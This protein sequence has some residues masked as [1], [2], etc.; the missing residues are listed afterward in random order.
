MAEGQF[1]G[2]KSRVIYTSDADDSIILTIDDDLVTSGQSLPT[3]N[4]ASPPENVT[5]KPNRF[6]PRGVYWQATQGD[7]AGARKF[8]ICGSPD[9]PLYSTNAQT[10]LTIDGVAGV[11]TGR[12]GERVTF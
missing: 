12:R 7:L 4:P 11:T 6:K 9:A 8:L 1:L 10:A 3:Y 2:S 5:G